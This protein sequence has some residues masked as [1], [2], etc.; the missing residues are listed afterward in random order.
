[1]TNLLP[2]KEKI[3][4]NLL[5]FSQNKKTKIRR[6]RKREGYK[7]GALMIFREAQQFVKQP[8]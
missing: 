1:M 8:Y 6:E 7:T 3:K 2:Y 4:I 5:L